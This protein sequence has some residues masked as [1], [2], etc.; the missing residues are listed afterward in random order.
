MKTRDR[1]RVGRQRLLSNRTGENPPT[2]TPSNRLVVFCTKALISFKNTSVR[3]PPNLSA[4][5]FFF[6]NMIAQYVFLPLSFHRATTHSCPHS[7]LRKK[8]C[9]EHNKRPS[10]SFVFKPTCPVG[11]KLSK[12]QAS[13]KVF[14]YERRGSES[15]VFV[16]M[17][18][19]VHAF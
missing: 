19:Q 7:S 9:P 12:G 8:Q 4:P 17:G 2:P 3:P 5:F 1:E 10:T 16:F 13:A 14:V 11:T 6:S 18:T 15:D